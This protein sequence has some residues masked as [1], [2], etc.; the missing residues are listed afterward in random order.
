MTDQQPVPD[1]VKLTDEEVMSVISRLLAMDGGAD[2][3][4]GRLAA[5]AATEKAWSYL[6]N[7]AGEDRNMEGEELQAYLRGRFSEERFI[8]TLV[9]EHDAKVAELQRQKELDN[10]PT[11]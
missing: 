6:M 9:T 5:D 8:Q 4:S 3:D 10:P 2:K 7:M 11:V 1:E